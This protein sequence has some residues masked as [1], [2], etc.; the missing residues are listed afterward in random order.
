[1]SDSSSAMAPARKIL[2][3]EKRNAIVLIHVY[4]FFCTVFHTNW[5]SFTNLPA[6]IT[7]PYRQTLQRLSQNGL[8]KSRILIEFC[9]DAASLEA[10]EDAAHS[11]AENIRDSWAALMEI[12]RFQKQPVF[13]V[14]IESPQSLPPLQE[15]DMVRRTAI[16][17]AKLQSQISSGNWTCSDIIEY[18]DAMSPYLDPILAFFGLPPYIARLRSLAAWLEKFEEQGKRI[19]PELNIVNDRSRSQLLGIISAL[20][21]VQPSEM[22]KVKNPGEWAGYVDVALRVQEISS[23]SLASAIPLTPLLTDQRTEN[24]AEPTEQNTMAKGRLVLGNDHE[25]PQ[26]DGTQMPRLTMRERRVVGAIV[27]AKSKGQ[28]RLTGPELDTQSNTSEARKVLRALANKHPL[29]KSVSW[30]WPRMST[31]HRPL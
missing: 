7:D 13:V 24:R 10:A 1:M 23:K 29:W 31:R 17:A 21:N 25:N 6:N 27:T 28:P 9:R 4:S 15:Q 11:L 2:I 26:I 16:G 3:A 8:S 20:I 5:N 18:A 22:M 12:W 19:H 30:I 14:S